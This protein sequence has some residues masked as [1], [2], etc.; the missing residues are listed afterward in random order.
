MI[1]NLDG[2]WYFAVDQD[3]EYHL[4]E[5]YS[6][7]TSLHHWEQFPVP[8]CWNRY[9]ERYDLFEG[10]AWFVRAFELEELPPHPVARLEFEG[11]NY[12]AQVFLN[13]H[14]V[15]EHEGGY[16]AF[17]LDVSSALHPGNNRL[18]VRVDNRHLRLRL[19]AVLGWYNYGGIHRG[20][21]LRITPHA[22]LTAITLRLTPTE[23]GAAGELLV[24]AVVSGPVTGSRDL[25]LFARLLDP[26]GACVWSG[27]EA[28]YSLPLLPGSETELASEAVLLTLDSATPW[29]PDNPV[30]YTCE[31]ELREGEKLLDSRVVTCGIRSLG[32]EGQ[33]IL[34]NGAP[35]YLRGIC[36]LYDHPE[37]G[38]TCDP[39]V[40]ARDLDDLQALGV[41]CLRS[42]FP[43]PES[44]LDECDR[45]GLLLWLEVPIYCL[46]PPSASCGSAFAEESLQALARQM[47]REMVTQAI[48]HPSVIFW[49]VGN[50]CNTDHPE[51]VAFFRGCVEEVRAL[52]PTRLI[53]YA[54]LYGGVGCTAE[55]V[56]V[57]G[58]NEY[59]GWYDRLRFSGEDQPPPRLP[60]ELPELKACLEEQ[61][62]LGKPLLITEFGADAEPG[63]HSPHTELWS[64]EYQAVFLARQL[65]I[66]ARYPAVRGTFPFSY[67][68][69]RDPSK[70]LT[71]YWH[72]LNLKGVVD[73]SR[74]R[75]LAWETLR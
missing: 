42:H 70:P 48:N 59:W 53:G 55:M 69:Y 68:D 25:R 9:A 23:D 61:S 3:P 64:E 27:A 51:A 6:G 43:L 36:Y 32:A 20:V 34:L 75:K 74:R 4:R 29:S 63:F 72:G 47:L 17:S 33:E 24:S 65:E 7:D 50:E 2:L 21:R 41:N 14:R 62:A 15:G 46:A 22:Q 73:Y 66:L 30:L 71:R 19:P 39:E 10:V 45:R 56:D 26:S 38:V 35:L 52:D 18:A 58:I 57:I 12:R 16:T 40:V 8:G 44:F 28:G 60:L 5:D 11:V 13:G 1:L 49:G 31:V 37:T 67:A 54:A